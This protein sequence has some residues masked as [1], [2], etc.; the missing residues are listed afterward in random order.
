MYDVY[1]CMNVV[2]FAYVAT[3]V[4]MSVYMYVYMNVDLFAYVATY[5]Y[6]SV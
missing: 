5:V 6:M 4:Y 3:Y 2:L 1:V